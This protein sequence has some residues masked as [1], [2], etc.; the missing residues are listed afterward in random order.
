MTT[1]QRFERHLPELLAD[2]SAGP[3]PDYRDDIVRRAARTRQRPS[4]TFPER[5]I[6]MAVLTRRPTVAPFVPW[7]L[8][9]LAVLLL[10]LAG[11]TVALLAGSQRRLPPPFGV[12]SNG[13]LAYASGDDILVR[14]TFDG[15]DRVLIGGP[16]KDS[17]AIWSRQ[18]DRLLFVR[19]LDSPNATIMLA[20][21]GGTDIRPIGGPFQ[22]LNAVEWSPGGESVAIGSE[23]GGLPVVTILQA[24]GSAARQLDLGMPATFVLWRPGTTDQLLFTGAGP[25][26]PGFYLVRADGSG[27]RRLDI[28][29]GGML[30]GRYDFLSAAW[31]PDGKRLAF[32]QLDPVAA[33][34]DGN[35][36]RIH[37]VDADEAGNV[38]G[39][40]ALEFDPES[41]DELQPHWTPSGDAIV[42]QRREG[43][44]D[45]LHV[46]SAD[47]RLI[48]D[49]DGASM[50]GEGI[51]FD[52]SPDGRSVLAFYN[53][54]GT[55]WRHDIDTGAASRVEAAGRLDLP[56]WQ[57]RAP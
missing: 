22:G 30:G 47:G 51:T 9:G 52:L 1:D 19:D 2:L 55:L 57:R 3:M 6:P 50:G 24:D 49:L 16:D 18:G 28:D 13:Q 10:L 34:P 45:T 5:W 7:R 31:S 53:A 35:G 27:L 32:H 56:S 33:A 38:S 17:T 4:W 23:A 36:F 48:R 21:Q 25:D 26:G 40:R 12:A 37:V 8:L 20:T 11:A 39:A 14:D 46:G 44:V 42:H 15:P 54:E 29:G 43:I 41:D